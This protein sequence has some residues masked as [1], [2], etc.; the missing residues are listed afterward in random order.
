MS[1]ERIPFLDICAQVS[2]MENLLMKAINDVL[3]SGIFINGPAVEQFENAFAAL[4]KSKY[5]IG[6]GS[7]TDALRF[8]LI[9]CGVK[10]GDMVITVPNTFIATTEAITQVGAMPVF[11]DV[12][13]K[14]SNMS[15]Q[16]LNEFLEINCFEDEIT[17][18]TIHMTTGRAIRAIVPV[19]LYGQMADMDSIEA[20]AS[21]F[22]LV[23]IED[24]CQAHGATYYSEK[25][26]A[27]FKAGSLGKTAAFSFY[28]GKNLGAFG[29]AG[30]VTTDDPQI[31]E[32]IRMIRDHGQMKKY[33]HE[34]EGYNGRLDTVQAAVLNVKINYL[35]KWNRQRKEKAAIYNTLFEKIP[36]I[37]V[38]QEPSNSHPVYHLY[39]IRTACRDMLQGY[40]KENGI[41]TGLHYPVPLHQ[42]K[43]YRYLGYSTG[44]FP[45]CEKL[46][47][48]IIS[49]PMFPSLSY[50]Q[51]QRV[52]QSI[53]DFTR[54]YLPRRKDLPL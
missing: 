7:G 50:S 29:E 33:F 30:A 32:T 3:R 5:A 45:V 12:D 37:T 36:E 23:V 44:S 46:S 27:W 19:H 54:E 25:R 43:A 31:A 40:L 13:E 52:V 24:A 28:P 21:K 47:K 1:F 35:D 17:G 34:M 10:Q 11:V 26:K 9:A 2:V 16:K 48:E 51:Q 8:S 15:S 6:V 42:Q 49:I 38:P 18:E 20:I 22:R 39:V 4:C 53:A 41:E 14:T